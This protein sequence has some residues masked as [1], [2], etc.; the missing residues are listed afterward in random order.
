MPRHGIGRAL[1]VSKEQIVALL[2]ALERF[3]SGADDQLLPAMQRRM[4]RIA[5]SL[6]RFPVATQLV[7]SPDGQQVPRLEL[8][9]PPGRF[10]RSAL[11]IAGR[12]RRSSPPV[13]LG[14][15]RLAEGI[16]IVHPL[17]LTDDQ[18][19]QLIARLQEELSSA[20]S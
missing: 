17:H 6:G 9:L 1:K 4:E 18:T 20:S 11:E 15:A 10:T 8:L 7:P 19:A 14:H 13:Y 16:L 5:G 3:Q 2:V 12:L